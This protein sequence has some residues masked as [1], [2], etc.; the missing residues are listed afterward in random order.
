MLRWLDENPTDHGFET[1]LWT[2]ARLTE[3]IADE[4]RI[5][6]SP[7]YLHRGCGRGYTPQKPQRIPRT[8]PELISGWLHWDLPRIKK[9]TAESI[10]RLDR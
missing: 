4:W 10:P 6:L 1:E 8:E 5:H 3:L 7:R 9:R 2:T